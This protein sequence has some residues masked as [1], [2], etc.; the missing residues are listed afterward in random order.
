MYDQ[1]F[2]HALST[3]CLPHRQASGRHCRRQ[4]SV[5]YCDE[6]ARLGL[7][8]HDFA[9]HRIGALD[10]NARVLLEP[11]SDLVVHEFDGARMELGEEC[12]A[13]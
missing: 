11:R 5:P 1:A 3:P 10:D 8:I 13:V 4:A 12:F 6:D 2:E 7:L 9:R